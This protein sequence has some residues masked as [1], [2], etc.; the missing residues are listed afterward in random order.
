[1]L[2]NILN[3]QTM[4]KESS[5]IKFSMENPSPKPN[6]SSVGHFW[7]CFNLKLIRQFK[8]ILTLICLLREFINTLINLIMWLN[9]FQVGCP[10]LKFQSTKRPRWFLT[11]WLHLVLCHKLPKLSKGLSLKFY[12]VLN[13]RKFSSNDES[14]SETSPI[15]PRQPK[16][17]VRLV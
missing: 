5:Q 10:C 12:M 1:M 2:T 4:R 9:K 17:D 13:L 15:V 3:I 14:P 11:L 7:T 16:I 8:L 6:S